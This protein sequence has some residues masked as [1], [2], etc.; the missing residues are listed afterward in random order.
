MIRNYLKTAYRNLIRNKVYATINIL[1]L[2]LGITCCLVIFLIVKFEL[3]FDKFH[4][5]G[6]K[7]YRITSEIMRNG[8][9]RYAPFTTFALPEAMR[10][11]Y[12]EIEKVT[13]TYYNFRG[14]LQ[15]P[16]DKEFD[17]D[18][19][20]FADHEFF[21]IFD[22]QILEGDKFSALSNP[23]SIVLT[24]SVKKMLYGEDPAVGQ[25]LELNDALTLQVTGIIEDSPE[26]SH[27][28]F[29]VLVSYKSFTNDYYEL[30]LDINDWDNTDNGSTYV[31]LPY[32]M[33]KPAFEA[34]LELFGKKYKGDRFSEFQ[35]YLLQPLSEIHFDERYAANNFGSTTGMNTIIGFAGIGIILLIAACINFINL[36]TAQSVTRAK[37]VGIRKVMGAFK[38]QLIYQFLSEVMILC[39]ISSIIGVGLTELSLPFINGLIDTN[40]SLNLFTDLPVQL[41]IAGLI[42]S[43]TILAGL[44]PSFIL[45][46]FQP[47]TVL[48]GKSASSKGNM[49]LRKFLV[50]TQFLIAQVLIIATI[51]VFNQ[52]DFFK[53]KPLGFETDYV[54]NFGIGQVDSTKKAFFK[55]QLL[56]NPDI[57]HVSIFSSPPSQNMHLNGSFK[58]PERDAEVRH[59]TFYRS[60]D[61]DYIETYG[62]ELLA[63]KDIDDEIGKAVP[64]VVVNQSLLKKYKITNPNDAIGEPIEAYWG[65]GKSRIVGVIKDFH[66]RSLQNEITPLLLFY[67]PNYHWR[68]AMRLTGNNISRNLEYITEV[69]SEIFP[70]N[71]F[72]YQFE[73]ERLAELYAKEENTFSAFQMFAFIAIAICCLGLFGLVSFIAN[74]KIKE[75][76]IRKAL[77]ANVGHILVLFSQQFSKP[78]IIAFVIAAPTGYLL[79]EEWLSAFAYQIDISIWTFIITGISTVCVAGFTVGFHSYRSAKAN[80]VDS[81]R[82]E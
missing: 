55:T 14:S 43:L 62:L 18:H 47:A 3:S 7:I 82:C 27:Q 30:D 36:S 76:G 28:P 1:G 59:R 2:G 75:V 23:N 16:S 51:V 19:V 68:G 50:I 11:D 60:V 5:K 31:V 35:K 25:I 52:I 37:E 6:D 20:L 12:P 17:V 26:N 29:N 13:Q 57:L 73:N 58:L 24:E 72:N 78:L 21:N 81:L 41:F 64:G 69:H 67:N 39:T 48:R 70:D 71:Y 66:N 4:S 38:G 33:D 22:Y 9:I 45:S 65:V 49:T 15:L 54:L 79:M 53:N 10:N 77:G 80:P 44:Y 56:K 8:T 42:V 34:G 32:E 63:G 74:Q 40:L 46:R 61:K